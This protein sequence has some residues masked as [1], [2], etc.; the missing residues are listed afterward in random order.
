MIDKGRQCTQSRQW[1]AHRQLP[2]TITFTFRWHPL[3]LNQTPLLAADALCFERQGQAVFGP[4]GF[5]LPAGGLLQ[6][7]GSNGSGKTTLLRVLAGL[8]RPSSGELFFDGQPASSDARSRYVAYLGHL[9]GLKAELGCLHNL[10]A[11]C[12]LLGRRA[13]QTPAAALGIVGLAGDEQVPAH[14][15]SAGQRRRLALAR[16]WLSPAPVWLL[17]EP[18]ANLD[19][20]GMDL[21]QRMLAAHLRSNGAAVLTCHGQFNGTALPHQQLDLDAQV[22]A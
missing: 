6:V 7:S 3:T 4:L 20:E 21:V 13:R 11:A 9:P 12:G 14:S 8:A 16:L 22:G 5:S 18:Y 19:S 15:L 2:A 17:D 10:Q 1:L